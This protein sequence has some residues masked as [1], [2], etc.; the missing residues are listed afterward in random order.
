MYLT[1]I[2]NLFNLLYLWNYKQQ[3]I[4]L[5]DTRQD[6]PS[7]TQD[8]ELSFLWCITTANQLI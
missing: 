8:T 7:T 2:L 3:E 6:F 4:K 5:Q 1:Y